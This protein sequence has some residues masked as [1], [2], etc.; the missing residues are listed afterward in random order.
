MILGLVA[1]ARTRIETEDEISE[2]LTAALDHI[3]ADR[4]TAAP[5]CGLGM[6]DRHT[7]LAKL[8]NLARAAKNLP[9]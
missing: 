5:D 8:E 6:L 1:I 3:D 4:L 2:R 7:A 9:G